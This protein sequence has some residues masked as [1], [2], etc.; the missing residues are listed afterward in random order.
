MNLTTRASL[1]LAPVTLAALMALFCTNLSA[2]ASSSDSKSI[3][4]VADFSLL[5]HQGNFRHLFYYAKDPQ[6][7]AIVLFVQGNGCPLVRKRVPELKRLRDAYASKG[8]LF[9]MINAN[10][11]DQ[12]DEVVKE[13]AEFGIDLPILMDETQLVAK[14]LKITHTGEAIVIE[15]NSWRIRYRGAIDDS[16]SYETQK[17]TVQHEYLKEAL[18]AILAGE[19][20]KTKPTVAPGCAITFAKTQAKV[21]YTETIAPLLKANCVQCH[22]RGGIGPFSMASY[23]KVQGWSDMIREVLVTRRMPPWQADP[24]VGKFDNDFSLSP[25]QIRTLVQWID[26]G[27]PRGKGADPLVGYQPELPEWKLGTPDYMI[28]I[29]EQSVAAEGVFDYRYITVQAPNTEDVW[30]RAVE[31]VPGNTHVL[32]HIIAT[33]VMPGEDRNKQQKGL[34][35]YAPGLGPD[36]L[37]AGTGRLLKAGCSIVFQLHYTASGKAETDRSRLG[38]YVS[39]NP[40]EQEL[41]SGV[42]INS[43]FKIPPGDRESVAS[44]S[45]R[46]D[47][48][49]LLYSMN[50][51]MHL[52]GKWMRYTAHYPDG[53]EELLLNVPNYRFD[54]QHTYNLKVPKPMP[55]GTKL[56][57]EAAWDNS[58]LNLNNPDSTAT[59]GWGEQTF[60]EM[61]FASYRYTYPDAKLPDAKTT[62]KM[63]SELN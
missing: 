42:L 2:G 41:Q 25:E 28:K 46:F 23:E 16:L 24:H 34:A 53:T 39:K 19:D 57:V 8:V 44:K 18:D 3:D 47:R 7:R 20:I 49:A 29:P 43:E 33:T 11:Q 55:K 1:L 32:H 6:T 36:L 45:Y 13:A 12:R 38:L 52:R 22:T 40:P 14:G 37:P 61:F 15:P 30:L 60:N 26:A 31:I 54:W 63:T 35:G 17:P 21:S 48:D 5:D 50:P 51:H 58:P 62:E 56:V 9:W 27:A 4:S 10:L 59:V